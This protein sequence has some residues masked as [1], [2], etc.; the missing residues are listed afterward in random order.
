LLQPEISLKASN[1][2]AADIIALVEA[3]AGII[4]LTTP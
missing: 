1:A 2:H 4:F 3:M